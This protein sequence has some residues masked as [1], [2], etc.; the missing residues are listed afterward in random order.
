M[1]INSKVMA[2]KNLFAAIIL[3]NPQ[4]V[5]INLARL[6]IQVAPHGLTPEAVQQACMQLCPDVMP[7][8][9]VAQ[10]MAAILNVQVQPNA[11]YSLEL[12]QLQAQSGGK[13]MGQLAYEL[14]YNGLTSD[15]AASS[16]E[17]LATVNNPTIASVPA[18]SE[19]NRKVV[20]WLVGILALIGLM[21]VM[22]VLAKATKK[23]IS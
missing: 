7:T 19:R 1:V 21:T 5:A 17:S 10:V 20:Q 3:N 16:A 12:L 15:V 13:P 4:G 6:G 18:I 9:Q 8:A 23:I 22:Y 2:A 14:F 11:P